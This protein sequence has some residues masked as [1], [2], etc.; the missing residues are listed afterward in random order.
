M[1]ETLFYVIL[2]AIMI[3]LGVWVAIRREARYRREAMGEMPKI[4]RTDPSAEPVFQV[5]HDYRRVVLDRRNADGR[6]NEVVIYNLDHR[7]GDW[8]RNGQRIKNMSQQE[9]DSYF[10]SLIVNKWELIDTPHPETALSHY[11]RR[12]RKQ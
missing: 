6:W 8:S 12:P 1:G 10:K 11:Y 4:R 9:L 2:L 7:S 3:G 5:T